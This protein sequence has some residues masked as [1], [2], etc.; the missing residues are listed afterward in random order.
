MD[1]VAGEG[2]R[3]LLAI[4]VVFGLLGA[5]VWKLR[6]GPSLR[7]LLVTTA[8]TD[9][10]LQIVARQALTPQHGVFLLRIDQREV[11]VA[12]HP[13]G[14]VVLGDEVAASNEARGVSA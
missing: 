9:K 6:S 5:V 2:I 12:T 13:S 7:G 14:C 8:G 4:L 1:V 11:L 10:R 3:Q